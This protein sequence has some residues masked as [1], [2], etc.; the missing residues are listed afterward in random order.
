VR[1]SIFIAVA[2]IL[3]CWACSAGE[4]R[5][6][7]NADSTPSDS[8]ST[9]G[10]T[11]G[12]SSSL[13]TTPTTSEQTAGGSGSSTSAEDTD[14]SDTG[15][16]TE[17][18]SCEDDPDDGCPRPGQLVWE[19]T[20]AS[21]NGEVD[22]GW[23][24]AFAPGGSFHVGGYV[25]TE[26]E[27]PTQSWRRKFSS[28]GGMLSTQTHAGPGTGNNQFRGVVVDDDGNLY[29]AGY[30]NVPM[31]SANAWV[32]RVG[33]DG[34]TD[35]TVAYNG[36]NSSTDVFNGLTRDAAGDLLLVG[37]H[38]VPGE[39]HDVFLRKMSLAGNV[40]WTRS[41]TGAGGANDV[42][43]AISASEDGHFFA[44]G[45]VTVTGEGRNLW[46]GKYDTDGNLIWERSYN[47]P[48]SLDDEARGVAAGPDGEVYVCGFARTDELPWEIFVR[49]YDAAGITEWTDLDPGEAGEGGRCFGMARDLD[50][51]LVVVGDERVDGIRHIIVRKY[52]PAGQVLWTTAVAGGAGGPDYA[53]GVAIADNNEILVT[54]AIDKGVDAR[55][56]WVA[57]FTP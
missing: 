54:G 16:T 55:D 23:D 41:Y 38:N 46:L 33:S 39:G 13:T 57:R 42:G 8:T 48:A 45:Y 25:G 18:L 24:V 11:G 32:R 7:G 15:G 43:W 36:P 30:E 19:H 44:A 26:G 40:L 29:V 28:I 6:G 34:S 51:N 2:A 35:W 21:G 22:E 4:A 10:S 3:P 14:G 50:D 37:Y 20:H 31:E 52:T 27:G 47:G 17:P 12:E 56:V 49:R 1:W 9:S 53:R 5:R